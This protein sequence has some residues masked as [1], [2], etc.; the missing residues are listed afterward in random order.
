MNIGRFKII[1][2]AKYMEGF[3]HGI[4]E[5]LL[6]CAALVL[7]GVAAYKVCRILKK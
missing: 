2:R 5:G 1:D 3:K 6:L 4:G 7:I